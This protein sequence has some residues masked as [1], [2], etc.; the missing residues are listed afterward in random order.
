MTGN[1]QLD[2][3]EDASFQELSRTPPQPTHRHCWLPPSVCSVGT[4]ASSP[5]PRGR[6]LLTRET[7][8]SLERLRIW[9]GFFPITSIYLSQ[10]AA[11]LPSPPDFP[12]VLAPIC[13]CLS[14]RAGGHSR[15]SK[16][17][18]QPFWCRSGALWGRSSSK[19]PT[20]GP[21]PSHTRGWTSCMSKQSTLSKKVA[22]MV[23]E[24][25][26]DEGN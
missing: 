12:G 20:S 16:R 23:G 10:E 8:S 5:L 1:Q 22:G 24:P 26:F 3:H 7:C 13:L 11:G 25:E 4:S 9:S 14:P 17:P 2:V 21:N 6:H 15:P 18:Q 19:D